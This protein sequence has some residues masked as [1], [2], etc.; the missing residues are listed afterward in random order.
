M[1]CLDDVSRRIAENLAAA[2]VISDQAKQV[3][4]QLNDVTGTAR[5]ERGEVVA[6]VDH[7]GILKDIVFAPSAMSLPP[8]TVAR[9]ITETTS[10]A[11][12]DVRQ[13]AQPIRAQ[14]VVDPRSITSQDD[15]VG[16][17]EDLLFGRTGSGEDK[18][19]ES[20]P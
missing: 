12:E 13:Q 7:R 6:T 19:E 17:L 14:L 11:I 10:A 1:G 9:M 2:Q 8:A 5:S 15:I 18:R 4:A 3:V 20:R 16:Q